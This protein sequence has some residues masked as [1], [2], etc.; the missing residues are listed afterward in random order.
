MIV[1]KPTIGWRESPDHKFA[2]WQSSENCSGMHNP[3][4]G[5]SIP[6]PA[7]KGNYGQAQNFMRQKKKCSLR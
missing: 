1:A 5:G 3:E 4:V 2:N 6:P 7:I